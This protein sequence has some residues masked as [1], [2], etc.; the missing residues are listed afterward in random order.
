M[1]SQYAP[2]PLAFDQDGFTIDPR[3]W[4]DESTRRTATEDGF[5][6][7]S[8]EQ[9]QIVHTIHGLYDKTGAWPGV[10]Q[11]CHHLHTNRYHLEALFG[12]SFEAYRL[13]GVPNPGEEAKTYL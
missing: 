2:N 11:L 9:W 3:H 10:H 7:L 13:A 5:G 8:Q 1:A 6:D 12:D 4:T